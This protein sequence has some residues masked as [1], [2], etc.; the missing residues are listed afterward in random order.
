MSNSYLLWEN[1]DFQI[2]TPSNPHQPYSEG[3]HII[4][5]PK[6]SI[7]GAWEDSELAA[8]TFK[9]AADACGLIKDYGLTPW[10]NIQANGNWGLLPG[11]TPFFHVHVYG[12]NK[13]HTWGKPVVLPEAPGTF[14]NEPMPKQDRAK[15]AAI[16]ARLS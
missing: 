5:S 15:L 13:T 1:D 6:R 3:L 12:R 7:E 10:L 2:V 11:N 14:N 4:I 9:L 16:L 8:K